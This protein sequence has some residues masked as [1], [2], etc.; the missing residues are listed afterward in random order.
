M[1]SGMPRSISRRTG[2]PK[3]RRRNSDSI[4]RKRSSASFFLQIEIGVARH[5]EQVR[6]AYVHAR[7]EAIE[8][9]RD[10]ILEQHETALAG[11]AALDRHESG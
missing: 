4:A 8:M 2:S 5:P 10:Q 11:G 9:M 3:R 1:Y 7:E 6:V